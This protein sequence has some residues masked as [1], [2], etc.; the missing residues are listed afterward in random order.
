MLITLGGLGVL[1]LYCCLSRARVKKTILSKKN[2]KEVWIVNNSKKNQKK[3][4]FKKWASPSAPLGLRITLPRLPPGGASR[5]L[6]ASPGRLKSNL[7]GCLT[8]C[9]AFACSSSGAHKSFAS[10]TFTRLPH[11]LA[12]RPVLSPIELFLLSWFF[13][14]SSPSVNLLDKF[15]K[16][17]SSLL[18]EVV[19]VFVELEILQSGL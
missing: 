11:W 7:R 14:F 18:Q 1:G 2:K 19:D 3:I 9:C 5:P 8:A 16:V 12:L 15:V 10:K 6:T 13:V 17:P 4:F